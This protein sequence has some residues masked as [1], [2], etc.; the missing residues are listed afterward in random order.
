M[1]SYF[2][3]A[4]HNQLSSLQC[5][6]QFKFVTEAM[7]TRYQLTRPECESVTELYLVSWVVTLN[8]H[9]SCNLFMVL[10]PTVVFYANGVTLSELPTQTS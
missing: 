10:M 4:F 6:E 2:K 1:N 8:I 7:I 3:Y 9:M 5:S